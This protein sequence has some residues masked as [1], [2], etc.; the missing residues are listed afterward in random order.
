VFAPDGA[1]LLYT[2][3]SPAPYGEHAM[4]LVDLATGKE[5]E[6]ARAELRPVLDGAPAFDLEG[7]RVVF[8]QYDQIHLLDLG[9]KAIQV[10]PSR[11]LLDYATPHFLTGSLL[12]FAGSVGDDMSSRDMRLFRVTTAGTQRELVSASLHTWGWAKVVLSP[13]R[14]R[15]AIASSARQGGFGSDYRNEITVVTLDGGRFVALSSAFPRPFYSAFQPSWA[16]DSRHVAFW[17]DLCP[18]AGCDPEIRSVVIADSDADAPKLV[19]V[20]DG[21]MPAWQPAPR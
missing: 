18:Y 5:D 14:S 10:L 19:F 20:G 1:K 4:V 7:R 6:V 8:I 13:D 9:S 17:L 12:V 16:P 21:S 11:G 3:P 15:A 2:T